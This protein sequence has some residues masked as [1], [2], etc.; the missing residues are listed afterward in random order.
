ME[1]AACG[2]P[3]I[4][5]DIEEYRTLYENPYL[6]AR[7]TAEFISLTRKIMNDRQFYNEGLK[8]SE[9]LL[10][11]FDKDIIREKLIS[12]YKSLLKSWQTSVALRASYIS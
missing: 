6:K 12:V 1:A 7:G 11:Q 9:Q 2:M 4:Y 10:T 3:V 8:I 5:R